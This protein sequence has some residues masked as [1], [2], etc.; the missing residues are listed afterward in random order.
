[1]LPP[2]GRRLTKRWFHLLLW[3]CYLRYNYQLFNERRFTRRVH[4][5]TLLAQR[6]DALSAAVAAMGS[7]QADLEHM[8][9][10]FAPF[11]AHG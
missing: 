7:D 3:G 5:D 4:N 2:A 1:M 10:I 11:L 6:I 9:P 8:R